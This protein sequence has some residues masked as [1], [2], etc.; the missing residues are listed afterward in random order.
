MAFEKRLA[1]PCLIASGHNDALPKFSRAMEALNSCNKEYWE[2]EWKTEK[3]YA[4]E[5]NAWENDWK[6]EKK[7]VVEEDSW[8][9]APPPPVGMPPDDLKEPPSPPAWTAPAEWAVRENEEEP[10][11]REEREDHKERDME[12]AMKITHAEMVLEDATKTC[13]PRE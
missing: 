13:V 2:S 4:A 8:D 7:Q 9:Q 3:K 10:E 1:K 11:H 6:T 5:Y 12:M